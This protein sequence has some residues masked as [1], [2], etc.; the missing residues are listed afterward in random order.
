MDAPVNTNDRKRTVAREALEELLRIVTARGYH[1]NCT[2]TIHTRDGIIQT[3]D[4][5]S[6][7]RY[8]QLN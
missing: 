3:I 2:L 6:K 4:P 5:E 7:R 1:G 8:L